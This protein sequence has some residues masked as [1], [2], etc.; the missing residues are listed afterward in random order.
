MPLVVKQVRMSEKQTKERE[1]LD[2]ILVTIN[3]N[4]TLRSEI[5]ILANELAFTTYP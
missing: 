2:Q 5:P 4:I 1:N 3:S